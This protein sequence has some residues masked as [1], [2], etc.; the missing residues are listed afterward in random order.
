[1]ATAR[2]L[3][4]SLS[5]A[6][7]RWR[8]P[9]VQWPRLPLYVAAFSVLYFLAAKLGI[10]TSLPP[11][12]IVTV[13]PPN[14]IVMAAL[15][16]VDRKHWWAFFVATVATEIFADV[17][18][19]PLWAAAGYGVVNFLEAATAAFLLLR[20]GR[21]IP[22]IAGM[23]AFARFVVIGPVLASGTA[24]LLGAAI[25]KLGSPTLDYMHYW[26]VFWFGDAL[27]LLIVGTCLL[28]FFRVP[29]WLNEVRL[30]KVLEGVALTAGLTSAIAWA[31]YIGPDIPRVYVVFPF[32]LWAAVRFGAHG[33]CLAVLA[34]VA[35]A[36]ASAVTGAGPFTFLTAIDEVTSLQSLSAMVAL[37][38]FS[39]AFTIEDFWRATA[40]L[41]AE[42][43]EHSR[44]AAQLNATKE[45]LERRNSELDDTVAERTENLR[46]TLARNEVLLQEMYHRVKNSLQM[47]SSMI[48][49]QGRTG[50]AQDL[51]S[52]ITKQIGAISATYD[53]MH[54]MGSVDVADLF[55]IVSE[56]C[57][58]ISE[59]A[60]D[61][62]TLTCETHGAAVVPAG[63]AVS[64]ALALNELVTNS[65][66]H[67]NSEGAAIIH[68]CCRRKGLQAIISIDDNGPGF[69]VGFEVEKARG[70][71]MRMAQRVVSQS[72]G[73]IH[74][75]GTDRGS[76]VEVW[77]PVSPD[78]AVLH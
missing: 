39:L 25:Y 15:L 13:W 49:L 47:V 27:G 12:G 60:G 55:P 24:A 5:R 11:E 30:P 48:N 71:G 18:A 76:R 58:K 1:M 64:L 17:P 26:R 42:V 52:N 57:G 54:R 56:L 4:V 67:S 3:T 20:F 2:P 21:G 35:S 70:F 34:T 44:T 65:I 40:R 73:E 36:I 10:A 59:T 74:L 63:T 77:F 66:K 51:S 6:A 78:G 45:A 14:A 72:G 61:S 41:K 8:F 68:V 19:Y 69:P 31:F 33:A 46:A 38:T 53:M 23:G 37:S 28:S 9:V 32:L 75:A 50:S 16:T 43:D 62:I 7:T 22:S 29:Q